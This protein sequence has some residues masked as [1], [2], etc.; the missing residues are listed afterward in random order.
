[1]A[2]DLCGVAIAQE[3][4]IRKMQRANDYLI[5]HGYL[6]R[7]ERSARRDDGKQHTNRWQSASAASA[8]ALRVSWG[9]MA[10][11][12]AD[13]LRVSRE[14]VAYQDAEVVRGDTLEDQERVFDSEPDQACELVSLPPPDCEEA[15]GAVVLPTVLKLERQLIPDNLT[16]EP[17]SD[18]DDV[19]LAALIGAHFAPSSCSQ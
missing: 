14:V 10:Y 16:T 7:F 17:A 2:A 9:D 3:V 18:A 12:D 19:A 11:Q 8:E 6:L 4:H 13:A 15:H 5:Q 1:M